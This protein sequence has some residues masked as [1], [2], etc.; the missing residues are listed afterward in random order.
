MFRQRIFAAAL[1]ALSVLASLPVLLQRVQAEAA[2]NRVDLVIETRSFQLLARR[3]GYPFEQ[4]LR[5]LARAGVTGAI[6]A[7]RDLRVLEENGLANL[8]LGREIKS[9]VASM[10]NPHPLLRRL[11]LEDAIKATNTY[12]FSD[13]IGVID[14]LE[15]SLRLRLPPESVKRH[16]YRDGAAGSLSLLE[17]AVSPEFTLQGNQ[18]LM[19][20]ANPSIGFGAEEFRLVTEA[21]LRPVPRPRNR[22][23]WTAEAVREL[24]EQI[25]R[26]GPGTRSVIFE[27]AQVTGFPD[28]LEL[29]AAEFARRGIVPIFIESA[30]QL[31]YTPQAGHQEL[32]R[33]MGYQT[34]RLYAM[35]Q[36]EIDSPRFS[37]GE[38]IDK[39]W[40][41]AVERNIRTLYLRPFFRQQDP[42]KGVIETNLSRFGELAERL[43]QAGFTLGAPATFPE[44]YVRLRH[45]ALLGAGVV[46]AGLLWLSLVWPV[47][48]RV[49]YPLAAV[50]LL[51]AAGAAAVLRDTGAQ[52]LALA[53]AIL[54]PALGATVNFYRWNRGG[55]LIGGPGEAIALR[56]GALA[57]AAPI[58]SSL[59][60]GL[61]EAAVSTGI[62]AGLSLLGGLLVS[63]IL[64]DPRYLLEFLYFRGVKVAFFAP[65]LLAVASYVM[66]GRTGGLRERVGGL[67]ADL[68]GYLRLALTY[69]YVVLGLT[70]LIGAFWYIQRT[71]NQPLVPVPAWE[72]KLRAM[73]EENLLARPRTKEFLVGYPAMML[74]AAVLLRGWRNWALA[75]SLA[76]VTAGV[77]VVNSFSHLRT[78]LLI[79]V[80]RWAHGLW[81]GV[82]L[83]LIGT[84]AVIWALDWLI[85]QE[86]GDRR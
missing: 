10:A 69:G 39:W 5:D 43:K 40:R 15:R 62:L 52:L 53:A 28:L 14:Q 32:A 81:M 82:I 72:L 12:V 13:Q 31:A 74:A 78:P 41:A 79:S 11:V 44:Y 29:T 76:A 83:G 24:L 70:A 36:A 6:V 51:G 30:T 21:G 9:N 77:S 61:R 19:S 37:P 84:A 38:T 23:S 7:E 64:G 49:Y 56:T 33:L 80:M 85:R 34:N 18:Y 47:S 22:T 73:L 35:T 8:R 48:D 45:W 27:G 4:L 86:R 25:D 55:Q 63:A 1:I 75:L 26:F 54:F 65:L 71:G 2:N 59:L 3:E 67:I 50:G 60:P 58:G 20:P 46:G 68:K 17:L 66:I 16:D 42:D 57:G